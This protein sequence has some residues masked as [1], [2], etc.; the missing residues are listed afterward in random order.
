MNYFISPKSK[1]QGKIYNI[2]NKG[3]NIAEDL[4]V[5]SFVRQKFHERYT[6]NGIDYFQEFL[7]S[8][9]PFED[10]VREDGSTVLDVIYSSED[11]NSLINAISSKEH[12]TIIQPQIIKKD[13]K[14]DINTSS[15]IKKSCDILEL[16]LAKEYLFNPNTSFRK[17]EKEIMGIDSPNRGGGFKAKTIINNLGITAEKKGILYYISIEEEILNA[18]GIYKKTLEQVKNNI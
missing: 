15:V 2:Y 9:L 16:E 12:N 6:Q 13:K 11:L 17:L 8:V 14:Q 5:L 1:N 10:I 3:N 18:S 4:N 7:D